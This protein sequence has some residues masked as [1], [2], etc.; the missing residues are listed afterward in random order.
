M[1]EGPCAGVYLPV[2]GAFER[3]QSA[4]RRRDACID[5]HDALHV[6]VPVLTPEKTIAVSDK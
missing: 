2:R 4:R 3:G 5:T 1:D 6:K